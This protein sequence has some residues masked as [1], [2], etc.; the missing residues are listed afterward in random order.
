MSGRSR[1]RGWGH[2][3]VIAEGKLW[4]AC[5]V[6]KV[7]VFVEGTRVL[8]TLILNWGLLVQCSLSDIGI[9]VP[10]PPV[11]IERRVIEALTGSSS[12]ETQCQAGHGS[13]FQGPRQAQQMG[14]ILSS[15]TARNQ[16][17]KVL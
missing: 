8:R 2:I 3:R 11:G 13:L 16:M 4:A 10:R 6:R 17:K 14:G 5:R 15:T 9:R 1:R 12:Y 7:V